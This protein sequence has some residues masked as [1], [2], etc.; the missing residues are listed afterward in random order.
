VTSSSPT[1]AGACQGAGVA[2]TQVKRVVA[3]F[4]AYSTR[5][6]SGPLPTELFDA[7]GA[8]I[9]ERGREYGTTTGRPR[10]TG[11]FDA[12]AARYMVRLNG[13]TEIAL[14]LLDVLDEFEHINVCTSYRLNEVSVSYLPA[15]NDLLQQVT[16]VFT[17]RP[18]WLT[19]TTTAREASDL[20]ENARRYI[21]FL[22]S[23]IG[24]PITMVGVGPAREQLVPLTDWAAI[25]DA[26]RTPSPAL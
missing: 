12:V 20:P 10:R 11:W 7:V 15:R 9:R 3:V 6:G 5:V 17:E 8:T 2:P 1:S 16:P 22:E 26:E 13:V 24:A 18:G 4:K 19:D 14:T 21:E 23:A 25:L